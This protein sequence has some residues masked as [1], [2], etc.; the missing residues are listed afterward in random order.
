MQPSELANWI[1]DEHAKVAE[2]SNQLMERVACVPRMNKSKWIGDVRTAFEHLRAHLTKHMALEEQGG[3]MSQVLAVRPTLSPQVAQLEHEHYEFTQIMN[4]VHRALMETGPEDSLLIRDL[5]H[6]IQ[7]L[8]AY[9]EHHKKTEDLLVISVL[10][11]DI[12]SS[13]D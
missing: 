1:K 12:G 5:C 10:N 4:M 7:D 9:V 3:Y 13:G 11:Q 8:L 6:R 2:L